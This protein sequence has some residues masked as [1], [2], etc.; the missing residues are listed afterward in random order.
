MEQT[1]PQ[2]LARIRGCLHKWFTTG[3]IL[4]GWCW[5]FLCVHIIAHSSDRGRER[6]IMLWRKDRC[7][8]L[9][10]C[11][12]TS[13]PRTSDT[14]TIIIITSSGKKQQRC[15]IR[16][17]QG[18]W[19]AQASRVDKTPWKERSAEKKFLYPA[20]LFLSFRLREVEVLAFG[21]THHG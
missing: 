2:D 16:Q 18:G 4:S 8:L 11:L 21:I 17:V 15:V 3:E 1:S 6:D 7:A 13:S 5:G 19:G 12:S 9:K 14:N 20:T 10:I